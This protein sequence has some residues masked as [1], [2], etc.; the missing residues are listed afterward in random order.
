MKNRQRVPYSARGDQAIDRG[1]NGDAGSPAGA[2]ESDG[3]FVTFCSERRFDDRKR[4][5]RLACRAECPL[6]A[7]PL[8]NFLDYGETGDDLIERD[9]IFE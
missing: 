9:V 6:L 4:E 7:E 1:S 8:E 3:F 5:H 2:I